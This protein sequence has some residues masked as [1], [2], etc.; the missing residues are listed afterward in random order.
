MSMLWYVRWSSPTIY[1]VVIYTVYSLF[2]CCNVAGYTLQSPQSQIVDLPTIHYSQP[3]IHSQYHCVRI[4]LCW[5]VNTSSCEVVTASISVTL[6]QHWN[7]C[8]T[9]ETCVG[10]NTE[11][12]EVVTVS[13][14]YQHI[15]YII[16][17]CVGNNTETGKQSREQNTISHYT[18]LH[19]ITLHY[20]MLHCT[21]PRYITLHYTM[22]H[23]ITLHYTSPQ[24]TIP[25][26]PTLC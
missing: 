15:L 17:T 11:T 2:P 25:H 4:L 14:S 5:Q 6:C 8:V 19:Y 12:C 7:L 18:A 1:N 16:E 21:T 20:T 3:A 9:T 23:Y 24:C 26:Y 22:Q 13:T 10:N